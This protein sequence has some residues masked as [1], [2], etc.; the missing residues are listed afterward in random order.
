MRAGKTKRMTEVD[1]FLLSYFR[2]GFLSVIRWAVVAMDG[3]KVVG[4]V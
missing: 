2:D 1:G 4:S 3:W